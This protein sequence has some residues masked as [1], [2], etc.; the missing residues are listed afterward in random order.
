VEIA[1]KSKNAMY[2][3]ALDGLNG[4]AGQ[5]VHAT[6]EKLVHKLELAL[7]R[8]PKLALN[9]VHATEIRH[10]NTSPA[11]A[12]TNHDV[13]GAPPMTTVLE[14]PMVFGTIM[15][16][17]TFTDTE[18]IGMQTY[19]PEIMMLMI[20]DISKSDDAIKILSHA[21]NGADLT[22]PTRTLTF[23][24]LHG[25]IAMPN[26]VL[27]KKRANE[28]VSEFILRVVWDSSS[29]FRIANATLNY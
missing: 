16:S 9:I 17:A 20:L 19:W 13:A 27:E 14:L 25:P 23:T 3:F 2:H 10:W 24:G 8:V 18:P 29:R 12:P 11:L 6:A 22:T 4:V 1:S 7:V 26:A 21:P 15:D 28:N 5:N